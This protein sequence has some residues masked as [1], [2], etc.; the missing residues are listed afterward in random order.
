MQYYNSFFW[1]QMFTDNRRTDLIGDA[2]PLVT[3]TT[4]LFYKKYEY[5]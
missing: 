4:I 5:H 3:H 1:W 2:L